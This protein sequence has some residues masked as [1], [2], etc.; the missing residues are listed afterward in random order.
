MDNEQNSENET[1][2]V[3]DSELIKRFSRRSQ[4]SD[5]A[6]AMQAVICILLS[7]GLFAVHLFAPETADPVFR[8][9]ESLSSSENE[10]FTNPLGLIGNLL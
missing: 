5:D 3:S 1:I 7:A 4:R 8:L 9:I 2:T 10:L 6:V